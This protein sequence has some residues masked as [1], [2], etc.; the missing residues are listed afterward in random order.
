[1]RVVTGCECYCCWAKRRRDHKGVDQASLNKKRNGSQKFKDDHDKDRGEV[2]RGL[3]TTLTGGDRL[4]ESKTVKG[5]KGVF[6][7]NYDEGHFYFLDDFLQLHY[8]GRKFRTKIEKFKTVK[9]LNKDEAWQLGC[10]RKQ[11]SS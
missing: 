1:M 2:A 5:E 7:K 10:K 4:D 11:S 8:E 6:G 3:R 9:A